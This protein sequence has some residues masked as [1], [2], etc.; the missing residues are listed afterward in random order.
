[1][2]ALK[3]RLTTALAQFN[4]ALPHP[5]HLRIIR[6]KNKPE[7]GLWA[8]A[9]LEPQAEPHSLGLIKAAISQRYGILDSLDVSEALLELQDRRHD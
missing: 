7:P 2:R 8:L 1:M 9:K 6:L 4:H 5:D 3:A